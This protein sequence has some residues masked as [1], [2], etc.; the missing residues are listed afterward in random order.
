[1]TEKEDMIQQLREQGLVHQSDLEQVIA[2]LKTPEQQ[3]K[4][5]DFL[6]HLLNCGDSDC[7]V[8]QVKSDIETENFLLGF[9]SRDLV[10]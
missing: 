7:K 3:V 9:L 1:M 10:D 8:H 4:A 2:K 5:Q 6:D